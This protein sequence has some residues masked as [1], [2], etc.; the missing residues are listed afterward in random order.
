MYFRDMI[1]FTVLFLRRPNLTDCFT[2]LS[3]QEF[4]MLSQVGSLRNGPKFINWQTARD[5][6]YPHHP[7]LT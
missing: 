5:T 2:L 4:A 6:V 7:S 1:F 3:M